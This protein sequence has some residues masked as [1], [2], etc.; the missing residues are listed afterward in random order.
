[1]AAQGASLILSA[2]RTEL[3]EDVRLRCT[4]PDAH[5]TLPLDVTHPETLQPAFQKILER[6]KRLDMVVINAGIGQRAAVAETTD[7]VERR[8]MD[9]NFFGCTSLTR[10]VLPH[11]L[12]NHSGQIVAVSS[13]MG[14]ISTPRRATY[15][16]SK[17]ALHGYY[18]GLRAELF[19]TGISVNLLCAGYVKTN[20]SVHSLMDSGQTFGEMDDVHRNAMPVEIFARKAVSRIVKNRPISFIGGPER[21][22]PLLERLAPGLVR[23]LVPRVVT[24]E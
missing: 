3:L 11:F 8:I 17:H 4:R 21:F 22:A 9:V 16:A 18:E 13:I 2:R 7:E 10:V 19:G 20:I 1:M 24:R 6:Y 5:F 14:K 15:A 12:E 23:H